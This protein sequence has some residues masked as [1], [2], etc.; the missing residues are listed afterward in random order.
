MTGEITLKGDVLSV[1]GIKEKAIA[2]ARNNV[3]TLYIPSGNINDISDLDNDLLNKVK[4]VPVSNY[5]EI[6]EDIFKKRK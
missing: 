3:S 4:F 6:F 5:K 1:G 2:C